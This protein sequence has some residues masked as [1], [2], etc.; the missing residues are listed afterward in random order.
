MVLEM[1]FDVYNAKWSSK[2][3]AIRWP[4]LLVFPVIVWSAGFD[5]V[6]FPET[7]LALVSSFFL[8]WATPQYGVNA[9]PVWAVFFIFMVGYFLKSIYLF[10]ENA[11]VFNNISPF[12]RP[13]IN[14]SSLIKAYDITVLAYVVFCFVSIAFL[15]WFNW[16]SINGYSEYEYTDMNLVFKKRLFVSLLLMVGIFSIITGYVQAVTGV[17]VMGNNVVLPYRLSGV[18]VYGR[19]FVTYSIFLLVFLN[20][21]EQF[22]KIRLAALILLFFHILSMAFLATSRGVFIGPTLGLFVMWI[23]TNNFTRQRLFVII[24]VILFVALIHPL[25]TQLR[26]DRVQDTSDFIGSISRI[27]VFNKESADVGESAF[28]SMF[29][30]ITGIEQVVLVSTLTDPVFDLQHI[31]QL[32][33]DPERSFT[34]IFTQ[35]IEGRGLLCINHGSAPGLV[36]ALFILGGTGGVVVGMVIWIFFGLLCWKMIPHFFNLTAPA[37]FGAFFSLYLFSTTEGTLNGIPFTFASNFVIFF[38]GERLVR[39][40]NIVN[41]IRCANNCKLGY[42]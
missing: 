27:S 39:E 37:V 28:V 41:A 6:F 25:V 31:K 23:I 15:K 8:L 36:G 10:L 22:K 7:V 32:L 13:L 18:I 2:C 35:D 9:L 38:V 20:E 19:Q 3:L 16:K 24:S 29:T 4:I 17:G 21:D 11:D 26:S 12:I 34:Q 14:Q 5:E 33:F 42:N 30:R 1:N 40:A